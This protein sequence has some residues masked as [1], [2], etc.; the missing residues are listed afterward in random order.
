MVIKPQATYFDFIKKKKKVF[1]GECSQD[2]ILPVFYSMKKRQEKLEWYFPCNLI[3]YSYEVKY[4]LALN[5][6]P[7]SCLQN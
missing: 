4:L 5:Y 7:M 2:C 1:Q 6:F 3:I